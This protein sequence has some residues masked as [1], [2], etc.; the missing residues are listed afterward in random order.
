M[1]QIETAE[2]ATAGSSVNFVCVASKTG[3]QVSVLRSD[4][5]AVDLDITEEHRLV[6]CPGTH[7]RFCLLVTCVRGI[8]L[9]FLLVAFV[10]VVVVVV[11]VVVVVSISI[12]KSCRDPVRSASSCRFLVGG[13]R[14]HVF[15][16]GSDRRLQVRRA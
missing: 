1:I 5:D 6:S 9:Y 10:I 15:G 7:F 14:S 13:G 2:V 12:F 16:R 3:V 11:A 4:H 8:R